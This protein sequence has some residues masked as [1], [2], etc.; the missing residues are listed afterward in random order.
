MNLP[1][2]LPQDDALRA[3][4][5]YPKKKKGETEKEFRTRLYEARRN[6]KERIK[7]NGGKVTAPLGTPLYLTEDLKALM[8]A[9]A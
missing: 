8:E 4:K 2:I 3:L 5:G 9:T 7:S 1:E 6:L